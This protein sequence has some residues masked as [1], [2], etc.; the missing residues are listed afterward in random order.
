MLILNNLN[1]AQASSKADAIKRKIF[2][3]SDSGDLTLDV[4]HFC[5]GRK[6]TNINF[7]YLNNEYHVAVDYTVVHLKTMPQTTSKIKML[8]EN[9][10]EKDVLESEIDEFCKK[11]IV[12]DAYKQLDKHRYYVLIWYLEKN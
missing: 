5:R 4:N 3:N 8:I 2:V 9:D 7:E 11:H 6:I 12:F 1:N 10:S